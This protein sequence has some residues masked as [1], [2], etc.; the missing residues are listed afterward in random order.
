MHPRRGEL[1]QAIGGRADVTPEMIHATFSPDDWLIV[2]SDGL[3]A[4]LTPETMV[5]VLEQSHSADAAARR[6]VNRAN[7]EGA[8]DNVTVVV[9]RGC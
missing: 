8:A 9:V 4:R 2:C 6:L 7:L 1:M 3:T 5:S